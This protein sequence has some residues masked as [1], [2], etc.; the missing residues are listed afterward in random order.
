MLRDNG[1]RLVTLTNSPPDPDGPS[2]LEQAGL[3]HLFERQ[4]SVEACRAFK[5]AATVYR[6][7]CEQISVAPA[8]CM[9]VAAHAWD[10]MGAQATGFSGA[11]ITRPGNATL[12]IPGLPQPTI[13]AT[14]LRDLATKL[15]N[16]ASQTSTG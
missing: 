13:V 6:Y 15:T 11:L 1:F 10:I 4:L 16:Q 7:A 5:P 8:D 12:P 3:A 9:M 14:D 2:P